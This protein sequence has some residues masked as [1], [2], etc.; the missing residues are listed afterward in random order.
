MKIAYCSPFSPIKSG[1]SDF[2]EELVPELAKNKDVDIELFYNTPIENKAIAGKF[3]YHDISSL[4]DRGTADKFDV[5]VYHM[6][7][8]YN[9]HKCIADVFMKRPGILELHDLSLHNYIAAE[10]YLPNLIDEYLDIVEYCHGSSGVRIVREFLEGRAAE[11][12]ETHAMELTVNKHF[13]DNARG[14]IVHSDAAKQMVKAARPE[15]PV[16]NIPL[17]VTDPKKISDEEKKRAKAKLSISDKC[18]VF[19]SFG[20]VTNNK[21]I[22]SALEALARYKTNDFRYIIV[23]DILDTDINIEQKAKE[24]GIADKVIITGYVSLEQYNLYMSACDVCINL[25]Y[26]TNGESSANLQRILGMGIPAIVTD[27]GTF[28]EYPDCCTI[29][30]SYDSTETDSILKAVRKITDSRRDYERY[31]D[32]AAKF[33]LENADIKNNSKRYIDFFRDVINGTFVETDVMDQILDAAIKNGF[34]NE[35]YLVEVCKKAQY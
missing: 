2:S 31:R 17:H 18:V 4:C 25:R 27:T 15:V 23:G 7:N 24:L 12:W 28:S 8:N 26:P 30:V 3:A 11:P 21:R 19:G 6:G 35:E 29:K 5:I 10:K 13:I 1:I 16:I 9:Y 14:I 20:F 33:I 22:Y 34:T 32:N